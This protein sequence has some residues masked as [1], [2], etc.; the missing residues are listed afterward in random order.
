MGNSDEKKPVLNPH[1]TLREFNGTDFH[2]V[3]IFNFNTLHA[4]SR[5]FN[6]F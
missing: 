5:D 3:I 4:C 6:G 2:L 1:A